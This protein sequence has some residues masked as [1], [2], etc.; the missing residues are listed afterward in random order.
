MMR[1][2]AVALFVVSLAVLLT[3]Q[4]PAVSAAPDLGERAQ[5]AV[6]VISPVP[7][8]GANSPVHYVATATTACAQ[9]IRA[10]AVILQ[11]QQIHL[12]QGASL[13]TNLTFDP[14]IHETIVKAWD[15]CGGSSQAPVRVNVRSRG[16]DVFSK[17]KANRLTTAIS[18][19]A[20]NPSA[21]AASTACGP[22][23]YCSRTDT[24]VVPY[25]N[26]L[27]NFGGLLGTNTVAIDPDFHN[28][29]LRF[30][31]AS[32]QGKFPNRSYFTGMGGSSDKN[33]W[34]ADSTILVVTDTGNRH[35]P[36]R[37]DPVNFKQLGPL[38]PTNPPFYTASG[39]FSYSNPNHF[40][41]FHNGRVSLLDFTNRSTP[42]TPQLIYDFRNCGVPSTI[43]WQSTAGVD[44]TD[45]VFG[46][47]YSTSG[48]QNTGIFVASYNS[49]TKTCTLLN[50]ATGVVSSW[51]GGKVIGT[52]TS[53]P[54]RFIVHNVVLKGASWMVVAR[55]Q[56]LQGTPSGATAY[57]WQM[58]TTTLTKL[59]PQTGGHWAAG[60][61]LW[62]NDPGMVGAYYLARPFSNPSTLDPIWTVPL[63][64]CGTAG[65]APCTIDFDA[66][67]ATYGGCADNAPVCT[68]TYMLNGQ[69]NITMPYQNEIV[70]FSSDGTNRH[71][72]FAH[73][74]TSLISNN[75]YAAYAIGALSQDGR[76]YAWT[77]IN[78]GAFGCTNGTMNCT[79]PNRRSDVVVVK[80]Q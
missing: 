18:V 27:P 80:L 77:T 58:G 12:T 70:C 44:T 30:T 52:V 68:S 47:A 23:N 46:I 2:S 34:N 13:N 14:G 40:Y 48:G 11:G 15:N 22:P 42:P 55:A 20:S 39:V 6:D 69:T 56:L 76:F 5:T 25:P 3:T 45:T 64:T 75:F 9:G 19:A 26:P 31:D 35:I 53:T 63:S 7:Q 50:T 43:T 37:F 17:P 74:Y 66:H 10:M 29:V 59:V 41:A 8:S 32:L 61:G 36:M 72:R 49:N 33:V 71:W 78:G 73:T 21:V 62:F 51:P 57:A 60:C 1:S 65:N 28:P 4:M 79:I 24:S 54:D 67:P 38:Y 16:Q